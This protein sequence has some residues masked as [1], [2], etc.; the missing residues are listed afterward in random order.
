MKVASITSSITPSFSTTSIKTPHCLLHLSEKE[1]QRCQHN[2]IHITGLF[3]SNITSYDNVVFG[4]K[5]NAPLKKSTLHGSTI[6]WQEINL[7]Q[8]K[9]GYIIITTSIN[10]LHDMM[11][12]NQIILI[13]STEGSTLGRASNLKAT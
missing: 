10:E 4:N 1:W 5:I 13:D 9:G 12:D 8:I 11:L 3:K 2:S 6:N 7:S